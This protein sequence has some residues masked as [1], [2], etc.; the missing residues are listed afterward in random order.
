MTGV[1][2]ARD[3]AI[4]RGVVVREATLAEILN[5]DEMIVRFANYRIFHKSSWIR[6]VEAFS[7]ARALWLIFEKDGEIVACLPGFLVK[8][9]FLKLFGSPLEGW[10]TESM[11]PVFHRDRVSNLE[12]F[13]ALIPFLEKGYGVHHI[14]LASPDLEH[15]AMRSLGFQGERLFTYRVALFPRQEECTMKNMKKDTRTQLRKALRLG[16]TAN[17]V[18]AE[19]FV[20]EFYDQMKEVFARRGKT[21]PLSRNRALQC[22]RYMKASRNLLAIAINLPENG[23]CIAA[24]IFLIEGQELI[25]WGWTHRVRYRWYCP[26]ELLLWTAMK[27]GMEAGCVTFDMAGGGGAKVKFGAVPDESTYRWIRSRY[28]WLVSLRRAAKTAY[29]WQQSFRGKIIGIMRSAGNGNHRAAI[30]RDDNAQR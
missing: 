25:F 19:S 16:L 9:A 28:K 22:F 13:T 11:G 26:S 30:G 27:K 3:E 12:L 21:V 29:R 24:G 8:I 6:S 20:D 5:W 17:I 2:L 4:S 14:E 23:T 18:S 10:Q 15:D 1:T 7:G